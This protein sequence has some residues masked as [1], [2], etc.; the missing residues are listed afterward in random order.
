MREPAMHEGTSLRVIGR[1]ELPRLPQ[2][3]KLGADAIEAMLAVSA[4]LPFRV[5]PYVMEELI[6]WDAVPGDPIFQLTFPQEGMLE[7]EDFRRM[8]DLVHRGAEESAIRAAAREI[9]LRLNPHPGGQVQLNVPSLGG[10]RLPGI[11]HKYR[12]TVLFFPGQ[13]Q[14]CHAYCGYCFRWAQF[15]DLED[16]VFASHEPQQLVSYLG[17]HPEVTDVLFTGGEPLIMRTSV[18]RRYLEPLLA[19]ALESLLTIRIGAKAPA[20]W[21]FRFLTDPDA[22]DLLHLFEE[23]VRAGKQLALMAHY[24]HPREL[25]TAAAQDAL[26][27]IRDTGA[28]VRCQA[29]VIRHVNDDPDVWADL[30]RAQQRLGAVPYYMF[31]E[32]DTGP[33][34]YFEVPLARALQIHRDAVS[35]LSGLG[36]T[37][38]GPVMSAT[39]GK[40]L[41]D[42]ELELG[43][44]RLFLLKLLQARDPALTGRLALAEWSDTAT[45]VDQLRPAEGAPAFFFDSGSRGI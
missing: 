13:G 2:L 40:V 28:V 26:R 39:P 12:E 29:P 34:H 27:R 16:L 33:R 42:G 43:G 3:Q 45:W 22:E 35:R 19:P 31:V 21:P 11:Q 5:N 4:V 20:Y 15:V 30:C 38:R 23:V 1:A 6:D 14:T 18:L 41:L 7:P 24:S 36:R 10:Q 9:Q 37:L 44:R 17:A 25:E 32:R 8:R